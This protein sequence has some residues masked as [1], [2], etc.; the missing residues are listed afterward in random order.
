MKKKKLHKIISL[1]IIFIILTKKKAVELK[2]PN[3]QATPKH[4]LIDTYI[5]PQKYPIWSAHI[6]YMISF[7]SSIVLIP[8]SSIKCHT[9]YN[10]RM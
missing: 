2:T 9:V 10:Q 8:V 6:A 5:L 7:I 1:F 3:T 4:H